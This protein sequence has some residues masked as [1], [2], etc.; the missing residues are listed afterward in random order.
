MSELREGALRVWHIPQIPG[1]AFY[2]GVDTPK[3][4]QQVMQIL[5][6]Y[7]IF[8][9]ENKVKADYCNAAGLEVVEDGEWCEWNDPET[10][11]EIDEWVAPAD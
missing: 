10:G 1:A 3:E 2:V 4:A 7:D 9:F 11:D 5:A 8:Q 6:K